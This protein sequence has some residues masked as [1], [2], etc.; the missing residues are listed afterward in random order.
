[1]DELR[2][3]RDELQSLPSA[4]AALR[5]RKAAEDRA[6][7]LVEWTKQDTIFR[8]GSH[9]PCFAKDRVSDSRCRCSMKRIESVR[10]LKT[11]RVSGSKLCD[12]PNAASNGALAHLFVTMKTLEVGEGS[13][14]NPEKRAQ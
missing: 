3:P 9:V 11:F 8:E 6:D 13:T 1:M 5:R 4:K 2:E 12:M 7:C 14:Q 10:T